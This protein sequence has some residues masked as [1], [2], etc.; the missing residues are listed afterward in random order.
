[1]KNGM[2]YEQCA[3]SY[4]AGAYLYPNCMRWRDTVLTY[5][6]RIEYTVL[7]RTCYYF[8]SHESNDAASRPTVNR[9]DTNY[10]MRNTLSRPEN[11]GGSQHTEFKMLKCSICSF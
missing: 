1:M 10:A 3:T 11:V 4:Q 8:E 5:F 6:Y 2:N 7:I 9:D